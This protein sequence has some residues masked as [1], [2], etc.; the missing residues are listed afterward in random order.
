MGEVVNYISIV[1]L[2]GF[3]MVYNFNHISNLHVAKELRN[4]ET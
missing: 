2:F 3:F 4:I 1:F